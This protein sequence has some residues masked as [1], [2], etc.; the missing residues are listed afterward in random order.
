VKRFLAIALLCAGCASRP[1]PQPPQPSDVE[2]YLPPDVE[3]IS[4]LGK[5]LHPPELGPEE[6]KRREDALT[7]AQAALEANPDS[8]DA[9]LAAADRLADLGR[10]REAIDVYTDAIRRHP[11]SAKLYRS[12]AHRDI[13]VRRFHEALGDLEFAQLLEREKPD[14]AERDQIFYLLGLAHYL[15]GDFERALA[16]YRQ[17]LPLS[18]TPDRLVST[19]D[20]M[21]MTL[22]RLGRS[23]P[24]EKLLEPISI[25]LDVKDGVAHHKLLLMYGGEI[26]PEELSA[27]N[28]DTVDGAMILYGVGNWYFVNGQPE[29]ALPVW[30]KILDGNQSFA[31]GYIA[32]EAEVARFDK[33]VRRPSQ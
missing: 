21:Y 3:A 28:V 13:N 26:A 16:A 20:W 8:I 17:S 18:K 24:A 29:R 23:Q 15:R 7:K 10:Y 30:R 22:R 6:Q 19:S 11:D 14:A 31:F 1:A 5:P 9:A 27:Q 4:L 32:A 12:R 25:D 33:A 2:Q